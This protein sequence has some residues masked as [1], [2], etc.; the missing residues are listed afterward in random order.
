VISVVRGQGTGPHEVDGISG[1]TL[2]GKFLTRGLK[3]TL[4]KYEHVSIKFRKNKS[5]DLSEIKTG[6]QG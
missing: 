6:E 3:D 4:K 1:A 5:N 2:T